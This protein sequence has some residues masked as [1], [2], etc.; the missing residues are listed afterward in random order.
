[1]EKFFKDLPLEL[2]NYIMYKCGGI[3]HKTAK[4]LKDFINDNNLYKTNQENITN[5]YQL[6][7]S[8]EFLSKRLPIIIM[9]E[10]DSEG[11]ETVSFEYPM[12][13]E[14]FDYLYENDNEFFLDYEG[15]FNG[16][17]LI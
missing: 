17:G 6:L 3:E 14:H 12:S 13:Q 10:Y 8:F 16:Q 4:I 9:N 1:M 7:R 11:E 2:K 15:S 5:F